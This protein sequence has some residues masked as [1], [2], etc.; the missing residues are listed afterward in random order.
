M[1]YKETYHKETYKETSVTQSM[2]SMCVLERAWAQPL[3]DGGPRSS[4]NANKKKKKTVECEDN[5]L[6]D[7]A[8]FA[9]SPLSPG[10]FLLHT[11]W[12]LSE[13]EI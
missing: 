7:A 3:E 4:Q 9:V 2:V 5:D 8:T 13:C 10:V 6:F 1:P 11:D 12:G